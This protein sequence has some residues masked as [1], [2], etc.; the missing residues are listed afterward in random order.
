MV[1][2]EE[3]GRINA[4]E[5]RGNSPPMNLVGERVR[6]LTGQIAE[7]EPPSTMMVLPVT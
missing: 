1:T 7:N 5:I 2:Q 6:G 3:N 4:D